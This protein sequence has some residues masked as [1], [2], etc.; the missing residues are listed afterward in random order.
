M[1]RNTDDEDHAEEQQQD[2]Q[3]HRDIDRQQVREQAGGDIANDS[4]GFAESLRLVGPR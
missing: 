3:G 1:Q 2:Q 4:A